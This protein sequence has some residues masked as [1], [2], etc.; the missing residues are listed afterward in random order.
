MTVPLTRYEQRKAATHQSLLDAAR[1]VIVAKGYHHV[2]I[3]D[4]TDRANVSKATFYKHFPNKEECVRELMQQGFDGL[5]KQ[6]MSVERPT[7]VSPEWVR[8]SLE[9]VFNWAE[10]NREFLLIMIGGAASS[11][12]NAFGRRYAADIIEHTIISEFVRDGGPTRF[13]PTIEAQIVTGMMIQLLGWWLENDTGYSAA[14][15]AD[16]VHVALLHGIIQQG[17]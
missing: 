4:I 14:T 12:L 11:Q 13:P 15:M 9:Q 6:I 5:I 17:E 7:P 16:F 2:D 3:L 1:A 8:S 10:D